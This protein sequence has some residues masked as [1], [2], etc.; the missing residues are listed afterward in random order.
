MRQR[1]EFAHG[2]APGHRGDDFVN[3]LSAALEAQVL[4]RVQ[5]TVLSALG[6]PAKRGPGRPPKVKSENA[7]ESE[8]VRSLY[9]W[10]FGISLVSLPPRYLRSMVD[11]PLARG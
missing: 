6:T 7:S 11:A 8:S 1:G 4:A 9:P 10:R 3:Q 5:S 2:H